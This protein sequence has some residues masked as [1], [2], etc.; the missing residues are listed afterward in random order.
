MG[1]PVSRAWLVIGVT[2]ELTGCG[3]LKHE[4]CRST[5]YINQII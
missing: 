5:Y 1:H 4:M 2:C 3:Y